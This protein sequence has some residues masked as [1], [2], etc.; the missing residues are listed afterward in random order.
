MGIKDCYTTIAAIFGVIIFI[1]IYLYS[2]VEHGLIGIALGWIPA[3]MA[4][5]FLGMLWPLLLIG[6]IFVFKFI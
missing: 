4:G 6:I 2:I 5:G 1:G 3:I